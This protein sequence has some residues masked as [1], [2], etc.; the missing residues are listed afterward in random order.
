MPKAASVKSRKRT[1]SVH[2]EQ[3][4]AN[5][6]ADI[7]GVDLTQALSRSDFKTVRDA[8]V[9]HE[10]LVFRNQNLTQTQ[11]IDFVAQFGE[12]TVHPFATSL[13][14]HPE[15]IVLDNNRDN[16]A[17]VHRPVAF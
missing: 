2:I 10:V 9:E 13:P 3:L 4:G 12:L 7:G 6:G 17:L 5:I 15:L 16:P 11:Y 1:S 14:E 8:F